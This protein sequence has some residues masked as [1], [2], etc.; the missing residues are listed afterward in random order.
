M[1]DAH[2]LGLLL[3]VGVL[4]ARHLV[5]INLR[6]AVWFGGVEGFVVGAHVRPVVGILVED[7]EIEFGIA[8]LVLQCGDDGIQIRLRGAS[9]QAGNRGITNVHACLGCHENGTGID[10]RCIVRVE[11]D[12]QPDFLFQGL[13]QLFRGH[14]AA[15]SGHVLDA[16]HVSAHFFQLLRELDVVGE[17]ILV[18]LGIEDVSCVTNRAFAQGLRLL[19][20]GGHRLGKIGQVVEAVENAED[21]HAVLCGMFDE[22][23]NHV[24]RVVGVTDGV[25]TTEQ[26]LEQNVRHA[27]PKLAQ[28]L[29]G[30]FLEET[31]GGV[32]GGAAPHFQREKFGG[33]MRHGIGDRQHVVGPHARRQQRLVGIAH[34]RIR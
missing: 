10:A 6:R 8:A 14:G 21:V 23:A 18:P 22:T 7:I 20:H 3:E 28:T 4:S 32:K 29:P 30:T 11:M 26:H 33:A 5:Q 9:A 25:G 15:E 17:I 31:H 12:G 19:T 27:F 24:V 2:A 34:G 13:D 16:K 1:T